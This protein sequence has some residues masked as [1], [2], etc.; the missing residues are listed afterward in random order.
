MQEFFDV[1]RR[2]RKNTREICRFLRKNPSLVMSFPLPFRSW[3]LTMIQ[4]TKLRSL[5]Q[6][7]STYVDK[8]IRVMK[9]LREQTLRSLR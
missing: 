3:P 9:G 4:R 2:L 1:A 5:H 8:F 6:E 7:S